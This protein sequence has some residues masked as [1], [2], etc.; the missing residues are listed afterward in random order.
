MAR[1]VWDPDVA[2]GSLAEA[3]ELADAGSLLVVGGE[4]G[5]L[6]GG[7][8]HVVGLSSPLHMRLLSGRSSTAVVARSAVVGTG[9]TPYPRAEG[10]VR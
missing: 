9:R 1:R 7:I 6:L 8:G 2:S 4:P 3:G 5:R 10:G